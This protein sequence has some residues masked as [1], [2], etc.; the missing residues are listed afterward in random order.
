MTY[1]YV[2][3][4]Y[5]FDLTIEDDLAKRVLTYCK[6]LPVYPTI[7]CGG[8]RFIQ[9]DEKGAVPEYVKEHAA[10][11]IVEKS[12][13]SKDLI[14][15]LDD[16]AYHV[17]K[18]MV[19]PASLDQK[20]YVLCELAEAFPELAITTS[21]PVFVEINARGIDKGRT[22]GLLCERLGLSIADAIAF[23]DAGNDLAMLK[24][25]GLGIV[26]ENG[27]DE[28]KACADR[29]CESNDDDGICKALVDLIG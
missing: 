19:Y 9:T 5:L 4:K 3:G 25:A 7:V 26:P 8:K 2:E 13:P 29:I 23:G 12:Y 20:D 17:Q 10:P 21:G 24:A 15:E 16:P 11:G 1:D 14:A 6:E 22:L 27:T 28:A 18:I